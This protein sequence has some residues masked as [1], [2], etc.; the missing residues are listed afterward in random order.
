MNKTLTVVFDGHVLHPDSPLDLEP[1][2]PYVVTIQSVLP[3]VA[4]GDV[5]DVLEALTGTL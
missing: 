4:E 3:P 5:W 2:M 1:N